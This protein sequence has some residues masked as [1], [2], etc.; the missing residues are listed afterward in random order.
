MRMRDNKVNVNVCYVGRY[1]SSGTLYEH[2][3]LQHSTTF[4]HTSYLH[5]NTIHS[6]QLKLMDNYTETRDPGTKD[7]G[8]E[9]IMIMK[10]I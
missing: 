7:N 6:S 2:A 4:S 1:I 3:S 9:S 5:P 10:D 8:S